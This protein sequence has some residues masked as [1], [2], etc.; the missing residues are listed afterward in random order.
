M[1]WQQMLMGWLKAFLILLVLNNLALKFELAFMVEYVFPDILLVQNVSYTCHDT[2]FLLL[3][4]LRSI[5]V[6][7]QSVLIF[8]NFSVIMIIMTYSVYSMD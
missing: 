3:E 6:L 2:T 7:C 1:Y 5:F 8:P 4:N